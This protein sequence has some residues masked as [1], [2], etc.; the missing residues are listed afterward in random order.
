MRLTEKNKSKTAQEIYD[1][2][3]PSYKNVSYYFVGAIIKA[4]NEKS[5]STEHSQ[6]FGEIYD[7]M[8]DDEKH[9]VK[10]MVCRALDQL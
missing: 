6:T 5:D 2:L 9:F 7:T 1:S 10:L 8:R 3:S 4:R